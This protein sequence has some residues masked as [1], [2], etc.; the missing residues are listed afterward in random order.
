MEKYFE[1]ERKAKI[2]TC[3]MKHY[4]KI[5]RTDEQITV[6]QTCTYGRIFSKIN[7]MSL[8]PDRK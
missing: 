1:T 6:I 5:E 3:S 8:S 7:K 2:I 4:F